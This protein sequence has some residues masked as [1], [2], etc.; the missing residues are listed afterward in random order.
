MAIST[1]DTAESTRTIGFELLHRLSVPG[2]NLC[3]S[4][5]SI[6]CA[7]QLALAGAGGQ[8]A[9]EMLGMMG[10]TSPN[11]A[12]L[13]NDCANLLQE[14]QRSAGSGA[15]FEGPGANLHFTIANSLW[16]HHKVQLSPE[17]QVTLTTKYG[18]ESKNIDFADPKS[19]QQV[20]QWVSQKT[21]GKIPSIIDSLTPDNLLVL[22]NC[23]YFKARWALQFDK[24]HTEPHDFHLAQSRTVSVSM[25]VHKDTKLAYF[26]DRNMQVARL[27]YTD[28]RF[29]MYIIL[30][31]VGVDISTL[32]T[33][34]SPAMWDHVYSK[35]QDH[36][37]TFAMPRFRV[38]FTS[39]LKSVLQ[40]MGM[41]EAF[42]PK[43]NFWRMFAAGDDVPR[44]PFFQIDQVIHKTFI[45]V[46]EEGT[47]AAAATAVMMYGAGMPPPVPPFEMI[48]DRPFMFVVQENTSGAML[49]SGVVTHPQAEGN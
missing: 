6:S 14:L 49:F 19:L 25:M 16:V 37:G 22:I 28:S 20:N 45:D 34:L 9:Q 11:P 13:A 23:A 44:P 27:P 47:E 18:A 39:G 24:A 12:E 33:Q 35:L 36:E 43:A 8:T 7:L 40:S 21:A 41:H 31:A 1:S 32:V 10:I 17:F 46:D 4:P 42:T 26:A 29:A 30:P 3:I 48:V 5:V 15:R 2:E 38:T